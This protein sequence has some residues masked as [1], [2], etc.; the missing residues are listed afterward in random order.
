MTPKTPER[1]RRDAARE[2]AE[3]LAVV[4]SDCT[5][6]AA[7]NWLRLQLVDAEFSARDLCLVLASM[8]PPDTA[9]KPLIAERFGG[10]K[11]R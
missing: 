11:R 9:Y 8:A 5:W 6:D 1:L 7:E 10:G 4:V 3:Q 2:C